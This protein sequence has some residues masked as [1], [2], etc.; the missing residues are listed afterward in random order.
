MQINPNATIDDPALESEIAAADDAQY[1]ARK[2]YAATIAK[3]LTARLRAI[4]P[5]GGTLHVQ[6]WSEVGDTGIDIVK[7]TD[8]NGADYITADGDNDPAA[9]MGDT[10]YDAVLAD[11]RELAYAGVG[12]LHIKY[13]TGTFIF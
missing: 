8:P 11:V 4:F 2:T 13:G 6:T 9:V 5:A 3:R 7:V 12:A 10:G 1:Q